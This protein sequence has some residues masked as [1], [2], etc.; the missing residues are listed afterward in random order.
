[1][2]RRQRRGLVRPMLR[3]RRPSARPG[4][5][6]PQELPVDRGTIP[7]SRSAYSISL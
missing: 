3:M 7:S 2:S 5:Q 4:R 1:M 6:A